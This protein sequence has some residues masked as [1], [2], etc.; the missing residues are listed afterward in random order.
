MFEMGGTVIGRVN[1]GSVCQNGSFREGKMVGTKEPR[2]ASSCDV[3]LHRE[4]E[5]RGG[6]E[7]GK[8]RRV[9]RR[10]GNGGQEKGN[11]STSNRVSRCQWLVVPVDVEPASLPVC[12]HLM[13][14]LNRRREEAV[15]PDNGEFI[16]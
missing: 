1:I 9:A 2:L 12:Q 6:E 16:D 5:G 13:K 14:T 8:G 3:T 7:W 11:S 10:K 15:S 4:G